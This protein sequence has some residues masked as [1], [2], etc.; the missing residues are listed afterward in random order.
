MNVT[1]NNHDEVSAFVYKVTLN[2]SDYK[3]KVEKT[4]DQ[5]C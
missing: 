5:L 2:K 4:T 1:K 3:D